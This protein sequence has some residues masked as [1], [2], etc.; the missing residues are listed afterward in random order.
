MEIFGFIT[1]GD[2]IQDCCHGNGTTVGIQ[3]QVTERIKT[4][5]YQRDNKY[6]LQEKAMMS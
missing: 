3:I 1:E 2:W 4:R 5:I 6:V